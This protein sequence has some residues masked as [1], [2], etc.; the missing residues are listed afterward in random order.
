[1]DETSLRCDIVIPVYNEGENILR[2][3]RAFRQHIHSPYRALICYDR[4]EDTTLPAIQ[5]A[6]LEGIEIVC[7]KN[8]YHGAHG[9]V[10]SG[11]Q[12]SDAPA[13]ITYMAD[14]D[15][16]ADRIDALLAEFA[17]G[18]DVVCPSRFM[19]GGVF[20]GCRAPKRQLVQIVS[21]LLHHVARLP[22]HDA[23]NG[24]RL[25]SRRL[26][27][28]VEIESEDGF[29]YSL[30]LLVKCHRLGWP[31]SEIPAAWYERTAGKSRFKVF[32][33][34]PAYLRWF[35][36]AFRTTYLRARTI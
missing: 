32:Q 15:Y 20:E 28:R 17:A 29:T 2:L 10:R 19:P 13:I 14:D 5:N 23:T 21:F 35:F 9:A 36:Y 30:E 25:F 12:A 34:A 27:E 8:R 4:D 24:F 31:I 3:L 33:W 18:R 6:R 11:M 26:I 16:N 7:V 22:S 1:M